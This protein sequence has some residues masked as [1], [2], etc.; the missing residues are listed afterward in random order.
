MDSLYIVMPAYN[1]EANIANVIREWYP[2]LEGKG[3]ESRLVVADGG[4][5]DRTLDILYKLQKEYPRLQVLSK[6]GT[7]HGTKLIILYDYAISQKAD[8]IFQTDS[9]GQTNPVEFDQFWKRRNKY[10]AVLGNRLDRKDGKSRVFVENV[11]RFIL[12]IFFGV[13]IPDAN[14]PFRLMKTETVRKYIYKLPENFNLPNV[15]LSV[16]FMYFH[17]N[18]LYRYVSFVPRQGGENY[19]N[20]KRIIGIGWK[21]LGNFRRLKRDLERIDKK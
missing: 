3:E 15:M 21:S 8:Y 17:E 11:L 12:W 20:V 18:V 13:K 6:P 9:D 10:D 16:Y 19:M 14:A 1:E 2:I 4:S 5:T 7:D